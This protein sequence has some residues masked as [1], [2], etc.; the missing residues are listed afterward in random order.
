MGN[1]VVGA[2]RRLFRWDYQMDPRIAWLSPMPP[3]PTGIATYSKAVLEGLDR[4]RFAREHHR[5]QPVWPIKPSHEGAIP[6][7]TMAVYHLGNNVEFH[8]DIYR[9]AIQTP[10]LVVLHDLALDDF[11]RGLVTGGDPLGHQAR[12]EAL[13]NGPRLEGFEDALRNEPLRL[14]W[15]A[16]VARRA[17]GI[18][19]HAPFCERY[20]RAFGCRTP[21]YVAPHPVLER[22]EDV[23]RAE[24]RRAVLRAP[25]QVQGMRTLVGAFGDLNAAKLLDVLCEAVRRLPE[26]VHLVLVGRRIEGYDVDAVVGASG[27]GGRVTLLPDVSDADFLGWLCAVDVAVD[28]RFPHRGEVSGS[29]AR[30]MQCGR[31]TVVS[32][33]GT[34]LDV[35]DEFVLRAP[36]GRPDPDAVTAVLRRLIEDEGLRERMGAAARAHTAEQ[37]RGDRTAHVYSAAIEGTLALLRDPGRRALARWAGAL[38]DLG[39][40][41]EHLGRDYGV[42]YARALDEFEPGAGPVGSEAPTAGEGPS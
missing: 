25:L 39:V 1:P 14:P 21:V 6:W 27:L 19:V 23:R 17:R 42:S 3:A 32:A 29:L 35:P 24:R 10:G 2:A 20:L 8:R 13:A 22:D 28:L 31:P 5:I 16:H 7:H 40:T 36:P 11:V 41:E 18:V 15:A 38:S 30:A 4:I 9:H 34:Y 12:R 33:T 37:A 26:D